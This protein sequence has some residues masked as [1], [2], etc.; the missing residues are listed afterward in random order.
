MSKLFSVYSAFSSE[1]SSPYMATFLL[2]ISG[3]CSAFVSAASSADSADAPSRLRDSA[4]GLSERA[5]LTPPLDSTSS[6]SHDCSMG[7]SGSAEVGGGRSRGARVGGGGEALSFVLTSQ[8]SSPSPSEPLKPS[9][10]KANEH[11]N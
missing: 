1:A 6:W 5:L 2:L 4:W 11:S 9:A 3:P 10:E 7:V 8:F